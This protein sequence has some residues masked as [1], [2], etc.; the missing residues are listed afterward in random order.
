MVRYRYAYPPLIARSVFEACQNRKRRIAAPESEIRATRHPFILRG[1]VT[2]AVSGRK[3]TCSRVKGKYVYLRAFDPASPSRI[4]WIKEEAVLAQLLDVFRSFTLPE[5]MLAEVLDYIRATHEIEK[6]HHHAR[7]KE[8]HIERTNLAGKL[9]RLTDLLIEGHLTEDIYKQKH[10]E[11]SQRLLAMGND[12]LDVDAAN[13]KFKKALSN[14]VTLMSNAYDLFM[15]SNV[16]DKRKLLGFVFE[17]LQL[18]GS[19]L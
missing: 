19:T 18:K 15:S 14:I 5:D 13:L 11:I 3:A 7:V 1:L 17:N 2:C 6:E 9:D 16:E 12:S 4:L 8:A 10:R